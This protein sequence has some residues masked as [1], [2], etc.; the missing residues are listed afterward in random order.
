MAISRKSGLAVATRRRSKRESG[1]ETEIAPKVLPPEPKIGTAI[2]ARSGTSLPNTTIG[3]A[4]EVVGLRLRSAVFKQFEHAPTGAEFERT[5]HTNGNIMAQRVRRID[6]Q[7]ADPLITLPHKEADT[8]ACLIDDALQH[9]CN[10]VLECGG[11]LVGVSKPI[12]ARAQT[13]PTIAV[14]SNEACARE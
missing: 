2:A 6:A 1:P 14:P 4:A 5:R 7:Q 11:T 10:V 9:R 13:V 8:F 3:S 12:D